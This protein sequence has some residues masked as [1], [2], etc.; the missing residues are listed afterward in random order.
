MHELKLAQNILE[1]IHETV[2]MHKLCSVDSVELNIGLLSNVMNDSLLSCFETITENTSLSSV[3]LIINSMPVKIKCM[4]CGKI[5][6][7]NDFIFSCPFCS[8]NNIEVIG[9]DELL[10]SGIKMKNN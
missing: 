10:V 6:E 8:G 5:T 2:P 9:G 4:G 7:E 1:I 3:K